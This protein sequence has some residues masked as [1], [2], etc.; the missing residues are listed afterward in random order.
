MEVSILSERRVVAASGVKGGQPGKKGQNTLIL[1]NK[2]IKNIGAKNCFKVF[3]G[4][5]VRI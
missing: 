2:V 1:A 4:D 5:R 3:R